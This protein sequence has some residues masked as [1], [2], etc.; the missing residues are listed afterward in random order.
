LASRTRTPVGTQRKRSTLPR[1]AAIAC[2]ALALSC[3]GAA[4]GLALRA[5]RDAPVVEVAAAPVL[6]PVAAVAPVVE[7]KPAPAAPELTDVVADVPVSHPDCPGLVPVD[8]PWL[9]VGPPPPDSAPLPETPKSLERRVAFWTRVWGERGDNQHFLVDDRHPWVVWAEIDCR[10]LFD[11][12]EESAAKAECGARLTAAK[13]AA[14]AKLQKSWWSP[15]T[16]K[17]FDGNKALAKTA[18]D[19][20]IAIQ[21]R[22]D[23]L[24]RAK[25]RAAPNLGNAEG[26]FALAD[27]PRIYARAAIVESLWRPE[28][29]SRSG[30]AGAY[31]FMPKTG[32]QFLTVEEGVVDERLDAMR[33]SWAAAT[34]MSKMARELNGSWPLVLTAYN[35]GPARLKK[36][37]KVRGTRDLGKIADAGTVGEFGFDGQ[38]YYSQIV[39][40][41]R[42]TAKDR[43]EPKPVTGRALRV[44]RALTFPELAAC[45]DTKP[46]VLAE[47]NPALADAVVSGATP[48]PVGYVA[49]VPSAVITT[50]QR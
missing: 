42:L 39:A 44:D 19:H 10:D 26:M 9:Q 20:V 15:A 12:R 27:V 35:T 49:H 5:H 22:T 34:Y 45:V 40:I 41:G 32:R 4:T 3:A 13:R 28:A 8:P 37:M 46:E 23:A 50:A 18:D 7:A 17:L 36:V 6:A 25:S 48:V 1:V 14:Q 29:L 43:F 21:G 33:S 16:L 38:N 11:G 2:G 47:A 24:A 31:Q 30:A